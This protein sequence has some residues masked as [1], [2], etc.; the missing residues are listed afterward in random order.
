MALSST[1]TTSEAVANHL[2]DTRAEGEGAPAAPL[3]RGRFFF[4]AAALAMLL[5]AFLGFAPTFYLRGRVPG[6]NLFALPAPVVV[7]GVVMTAWY[8]LFVA[9]AGLVAA[10]RTDLHRRLGM[11]GVAL[12][13][14]LVLTG[15]QVLINVVP[16]LEALGLPVAQQIEMFR[17]DRV[18]INGILT[19]AAFA[20][21]VAA[22]VMLRR[23]P[24]THR[25]LMFWACVLTLGAA[26]N[27]NRMF[28]AMLATLWPAWLPMLLAL[29][30]IGLGSLALYD[31]ATARRIHP[32]TLVGAAVCFGVMAAEKLIS[33][34]EAGRAFVLSL[35]RTGG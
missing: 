29:P 17:I 8:L 5:V 33:G 18:V 11:A 30:V 32:A 6:A 21:V 20:G 23:T 15:A 25:R 3:R 2:T 26:L 13:A 24:A 12:A 22:A 27:T 9:Q 34:S 4:V 1:R 28:G 31:W 16:R 35:A 7:H 19:L 14:A 10:G